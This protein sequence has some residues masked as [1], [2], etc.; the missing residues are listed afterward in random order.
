VSG[1]AGNDRFV[2]RDRSSDQVL[3]GPGRDRAVVNRGDRVR[4]VEHTS[5]R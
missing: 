1:S 5:R 2:T 4:G 3:G